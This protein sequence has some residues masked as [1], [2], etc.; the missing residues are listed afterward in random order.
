MTDNTQR[1]ENEPSRETKFS[2]ALCNLEMDWNEPRDVP[3]HKKLLKHLMLI[4]GAVL[5][6][7]LS[8]GPVIAALMAIFPQT[9]I[10]HVCRS[11]YYPH[12]FLIEHQTPLAAPVRMYLSLW[13]A[14]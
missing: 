6:Y 7:G 14:T 10:V 2:E 8:A 13:G 9:A 4:L 12:F 11:L 3:P 5:L 1:R